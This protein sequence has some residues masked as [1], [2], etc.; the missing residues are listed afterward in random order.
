M[1][2]KSSLSLAIAETG[3]GDFSGSGKTHHLTD[4]SL[5]TFHNYM[6]QLKEEVN[7]L[8]FMMSEIRSVLESSSSTRRFFGL[9]FN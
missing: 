8:N 5:Y 6:S 1:S 9:N 2:K 4:D 3:S 7:R